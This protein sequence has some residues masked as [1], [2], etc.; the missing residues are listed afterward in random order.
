MP[1]ASARDDVAR[2]RRHVAGLGRHQAVDRAL[3]ELLLLLARRLRG[4]VRHPRARVLADAG[5]QAGEH[6]DH[7]G[8]QHRRA[9]T[10]TTS[11]KRG[12]TESFSSTSLR[13][14]R[15]GERR[16]HLGEAER[17]DQ[18]RD[19][20]DAARELVPAEGEAV[21][22]VQPFLA[23]LGDEEAERAHQPALERIVADDRARHRHAE[24]GEPEELEG[25]ERERDLGQRRRERRQAEHAEQRAHER[26]RGG[27]ADRA[28]GL[29]ALRQRVA[30]GARR[31][32]GGGAGDVEQDRGARAAVERA[33]VR[34]DQDQDRVVGRQLDRE[35]RQQR[36]AQRRRQARQAADHDADAARRRGRRRSTSG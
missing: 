36:D 25:A 29:A 17:A 12:S 21:V 16:Q 24:Q 30:V 28:A 14:D 3:A 6:A 5:H 11:R 10:A 1:S 35:R 20:R 31:G 26:A 33:D 27:D 34:A 18:R 15:V 13:L 8:A 4:G 7:A 23:D 9:S 22:G 19:Q 32:V 2:D